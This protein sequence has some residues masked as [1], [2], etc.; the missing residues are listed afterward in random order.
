[1]GKPLYSFTVYEKIKRT[2]LSLDNEDYP[3]L[4]VSFDT[5]ADHES[6]ILN[7]IIPCVKNELE[8]Y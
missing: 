2:T 8:R 3:I 7:K 4:M 1:M 5:E 6:I